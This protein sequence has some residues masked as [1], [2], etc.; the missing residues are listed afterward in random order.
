MK[1]LSCLL[2]A[3][4]LL[5][6]CVSASGIL[7]VSDGYDP[8]EAFRESGIL[9]GD[10][11]G[12]LRLGD[13]I[14]RA[15]FCKLI[16]EAFSLDGLAETDQKLT[17]DDVPDN[18]WAHKHISRMTR[19]GLLRGKSD[20]KFAPEDSIRLV[21]AERIAL[22]LLG[23]GYRTD[24][25][26]RTGAAA[27]DY[28]L[29]DGVKTGLLESITR[30]DAVR[31]LYNTACEKTEAEEFDGFSFS[32]SSSGGG[33]G[34]ALNNMSAAPQASATSTDYRASATADYEAS[35]EAMM[36]IP[37]Q[38][39]EFNTED[40]AATNENGFKSAALSPLSTFS[41]DTDT[42]SYSNMRR[43]IIDGTAAADGSIRTEELINYFSYDNQ[44][45]QNGEIFAVTAEAAVCP[46]NTGN[47]L[48]RI[49]IQG[50][51]LS[52]DER[53]PQNLV[54][55]IDVSGS[56]HSRK[57]LPL[58]KRAMSLL[59]EKLDE[60][61]SVS[62][63]TYANGTS[64]ALEGAKG[65]EKER[66]QNTLDSLRAG[67]GTAGGAGLMLA[68]EQAERF[69]IDGN[70][71]II[72][73]TDGDFNVGISSDAELKALVEEKRKSGIYLSIMGFGTG[74]LKDNKLEI[75]ADNGNGSY[76][77]I[78]T[79]KEAKK[80]LVDDM[81]KTLYTIAEDVKLQVEFNPEAVSEYRLIG[82]E[83][84]MLAPEDFEN[85]EK[86]AGELGAGSTV[87]VLYEI[88]PANG[89]TAENGLRYSQTQTVGSDELLCVNIR[90]K[91]PGES[92]SIL[93]EFPVENIVAD[94]V[95]GDFAFAA[96]VAELGMLLND[97]EFAGT[98]SYDSVI[99]LAENARGE[100]THGYRSEFI[101]LVD[102]L[103]LTD[104]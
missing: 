46:W 58:V 15:E 76:Y 73:C 77:Y 24:T 64:V 55:L 37:E 82:Y 25:D 3:A 72:L 96:A 2:I 32:Y 85:D 61:D 70:N 38:E 11:D 95:D 103:R 71:R 89:G 104:R 66:I 1:K 57:K 4:V 8:I 88:V 81:T 67:G 101:S 91:N 6:S 62:I 41:I 79:L 45:P 12:D 48:A 31:L 53:S 74:N 75:M 42:A 14:T 17:F 68:Y 7:L 92:E 10:E 20:G 87:T 86:D 33:S 90:Y 21:D 84:R 30:E 5:I 94:T 69:K 44:L 56:M 60:R 34:A 59:L 40:Y 28:N 26:F 93:R 29:I 99:G 35:D 65:N 63:V 97:S 52:D 102:L 51:E 100:D 16:C 39:I 23:M 49:S 22:R 50:E 19:V 18:H 13:S 54:F 78:D 98:S 9:T 27:M 43:F 80:V 36:V 83:N 47:I